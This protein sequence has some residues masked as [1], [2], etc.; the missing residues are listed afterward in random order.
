MTIT[1]KETERTIKE[2]KTIYMAEDGTEFTSETDCK[3]YENS[4]RFALKLRIEQC[5]TAL[6][7]SKIM[8]FDY[9]VD[10]GRCESDYYV[11]RFSTEEEI[12]NFITW[13]KFCHYCAAGDGSWWDKDE[14]KDKCFYT[15]FSELK[16]DTNYILV[17]DTYDYMRIYE[18]NRFI[19]VCKK[20]FDDALTAVKTAEPEGKE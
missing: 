5:F 2:T 12:K 3:S 19:S 20:L 4:A 18:K 17:D 16:T 10:D 13:A 14:R 15:R 1:T 8:E 7:R 9:L 11:L 6:D